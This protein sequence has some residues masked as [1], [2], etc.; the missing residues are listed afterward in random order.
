[1]SR[2]IPNGPP[3]AKFYSCMAGTMATKLKIA[4]DEMA[5]APDLFPKGV[6]AG[7]QELFDSARQKF[8]QPRPH[9]IL[10][11]AADHEIVADAIL[12]SLGEPFSNDVANTIVSRSAAFI[13][14]LSRP[15][16]L[17]L[18]EREQAKVLAGIFK[19]IEAKGETESFDQMT[20]GDGC[21]E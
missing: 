9:D 13:D 10:R 11:T 8:E 3:T 2:V 5:V 18:Y 12:A 6:L 16:R 20:A 14:S 4:A 17:L 21:D 15:R 1:M 7:A 19:A